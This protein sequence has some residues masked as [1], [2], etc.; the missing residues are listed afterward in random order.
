MLTETWEA[1]EGLGDVNGDVSLSSGESEV[2]AKLFFAPASLSS[3]LSQASRS[4]VRC[5]SPESLSFLRSLFGK[6]F[7]FKQEVLD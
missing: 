6:V 2:A 1:G 7:V 5:S 3:A 4:E